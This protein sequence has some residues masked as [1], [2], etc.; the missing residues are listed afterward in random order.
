[1]PPPPHPRSSL[2]PLVDSLVA[3]VERGDY[4]A[5][6]SS[7]AA[8]AP[9]AFAESWESRDS[10]ECAARFYAEAERSAEAFL[11]GGAA[12]AWLLQVLDADEQSERSE[13][14]DLGAEYKC[15]LL[16]CLGV[17]AILAFT[18][19]NVTGPTGEFSP[20][21]IPLKK[22]G[23]SSGG[24]QWDVWARNQL[25]SVC[26]VQG[27]FSLLQYIVYAKALFSKI[28]NLSFEGKNSCS[29]RS[30][31]WWLFRTVL[32]QQKILDE[33]ASSLYDLVQS[34]KNEVLLQ[35][36]KLEEVSNY[37]GNMLRDGEGLTIVSVS[38]LEAGMAEYQYDRV[39]SSRVGNG[40][41][42]RVYRCSNIKSYPTVKSF[43]EILRI[44]WESTRS[45]TKERALLMMTNLVE[46]ID[47]APP[48][49]AQR[50]QLVY[51]VYL[52][53]IPALRKLLGKKAAAVDL[54]KARLSET[55]NDPRLWC[56]LG[57]VTNTDIYYKKA[58]EVSNNKSARALRSLARSAYERQDYKT[59]KD[60]WESALA[61]NSLYPDGWFALGA[62]AL[63]DRDIDKAV[64][65][66]SHAVQIDPDNGEA[67]NNI[68][69]LHMV[70]K[71]SAAAFIAFKEAVKFRRNSW[72]V[73]DNFSHALEAIKMALDMSSNK[74]V[75][76]AL[77]DRLIRKFE[78][79]SS[80]PALV[81]F[82]TYQTNLAD[83]LP[84]DANESGNSE[85][86]LDNPREFEHL[87]DMLGNILK[88]VVQNDGN[89]DIWGL[90][91]RWHK[92]KGNLT[93]CSEAL[94]RQ[95]RSL[96]GSELW[97]DIDKF[98]RFAQAAL[99]LCKVSMEIASSTGNRSELV[100][101]EFRLRSYV[102]QAVNF[103]ETEEFRKL[104]SCLN[105]I[106]ERLD[107]TAEDA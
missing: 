45:R 21:P 96:Q 99:Y 88:Q 42:H 62:A 51:G 52:P 80:I 39:D 82:D 12:D 81:S 58:L 101:A 23:C 79:R 103:S 5:A 46:N 4:A 56:S 74:W 36:G 6:L 25:A 84:G 22:E 100:T 93:M 63:K 47:K 1:P 13:E 35:F 48:V 71:K 65:A 77:F 104:Q 50:I 90:Y 97:R 98:K 3:A 86:V 55:P 92:I 29:S 60:L 64:D 8:R 34:L 85:C 33:R 20:F 11:L 53:T 95:I 15:A 76:V 30:V 89:E 78:E 28:K 72:Q 67:W 31:S 59:A 41:L 54:I 40:P 75:D 106:K 18:Q 38:Q 49:V 94:L 66:F 14:P 32:L 27:K 24:G 83:P 44:R 69:C 102:K 68:A 73:W 17:A 9:F 87:L 7:D 2:L 43:C 105:E 70:R 107:T 19:Q 26:S 57:D 37:W 10:A 91:A 16:L 61:L